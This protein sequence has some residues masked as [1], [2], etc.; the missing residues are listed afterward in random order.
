M[1]AIVKMGKGKDMSLGLRY[2]RKMD[3]QYDPNRQTW[4]IPVTDQVRRMLNSPATYGWIVMQ[5]GDIICVR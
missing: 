5:V 3:G 4:M 2:A 1:K